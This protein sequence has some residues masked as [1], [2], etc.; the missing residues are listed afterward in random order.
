[1]TK[2]WLRVIG[3]EGEAELRLDG[4]LWSLHTKPASSS[5]FRVSATGNMSGTAATFIP[6]P[7]EEIRVGE[8]SVLPP[9]RKVTLDGEPI[10]LTHAEFAVLSI[11]LPQPSKVFSQTELAASYDVTRRLR[12][13]FSHRFC[14]N[15]PG[16]GWSLT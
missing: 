14:L 11:L 3:D 10:H 15:H 4:D 2:S 8:L 5:A 13:K 7:D 1:M 9:A 6:S 16:E 12:L